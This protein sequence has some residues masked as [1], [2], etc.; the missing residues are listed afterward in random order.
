MVIFKHWI[1]QKRRETGKQE[2]DTVKLHIGQKSA[3]TNN[4]CGDKGGIPAGRHQT[5]L[6]RGNLLWLDIGW[7]FKKLNKGNN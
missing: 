1:Q 3:R 4:R 6:E 2:C 7:G 5:R